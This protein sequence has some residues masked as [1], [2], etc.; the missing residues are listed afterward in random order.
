MFLDIRTMGVE[1]TT[2][3]KTITHIIIVLLMVA[4]GGQLLKSRT[5]RFGFNIFW[6]TEMKDHRHL[7]VASTKKT[8]RPK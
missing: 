1:M 4:S 6:R 2:N 7:L 5:N 3:D 8:D